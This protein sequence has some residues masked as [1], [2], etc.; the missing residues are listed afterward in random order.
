MYITIERRARASSI[1]A[2][3]AALVILVLV[4]FSMRSIGFD[5]DPLKATALMAWTGASV[6]AE[7]W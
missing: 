7:A 1:L 2:M 6:H 3:L 4:I 5:S